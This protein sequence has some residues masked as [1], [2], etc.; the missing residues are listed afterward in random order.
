M[1]QKADMLKGRVIQLLLKLL[2]LRQKPEVMARQLFSPECLF[3]SNQES[4]VQ[5]IQTQEDLLL[6]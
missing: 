2:Y 3:M 6:S 1:K 5:S 4:T